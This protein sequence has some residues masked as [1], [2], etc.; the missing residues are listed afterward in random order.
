L[1]LFFRLFDVPPGQ[2]DTVRL[3]LI[4][5]GVNVA[6]SL[7]LSVFDAVLWNSYKRFTS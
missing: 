7:L 1:L 2:A 5:V 3:A 4:L 6:V